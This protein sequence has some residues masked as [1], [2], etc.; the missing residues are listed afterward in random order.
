MKDLFTAEDFGGWGTEEA[1]TRMA[2]D[3]NKILKER[4]KKIYFNDQ[5]YASTLLRNFSGFE[6][7]QS[8][9]THYMY[10][11]P[12]EKIEEEK[13]ECEHNPITVNIALVKNKSI[14]MTYCLECGLDLSND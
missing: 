2:E 3:A 10:C 6:K 9:D 4:L 8:V 1:I 13:V 11:L 12:P 14:T 5:C 7:E